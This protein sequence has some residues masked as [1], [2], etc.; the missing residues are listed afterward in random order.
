MKF[1]GIVAVEVY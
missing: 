1:L